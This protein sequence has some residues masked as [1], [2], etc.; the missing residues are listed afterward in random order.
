[1]QY[2]GREIEAKGVRSWQREAPVGN[3]GV[4]EKQQPLLNLKRYLIV[5]M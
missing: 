1:L 4:M 2:E 5:L 3:G